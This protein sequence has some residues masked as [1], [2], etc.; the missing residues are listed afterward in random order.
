M[1]DEVH[2]IIRS[3]LISNHLVSEVYRETAWAE[4][5]LERQT[6][7]TSDTR[8]PLALVYQVAF[9]I[10][11]SDYGYALVEAPTAWFCYSANES[12][13]PHDYRHPHA[14]GSSTANWSSLLVPI[15]RSSSTIEHI[16]RLK[17]D[18]RGKKKEKI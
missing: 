13:K 1:Q 3:R 14:A 10:S 2:A 8:P 11:R 15:R 5:A 16:V 7:P 4:Q 18:K 17:Y 9:M 12:S 6:G